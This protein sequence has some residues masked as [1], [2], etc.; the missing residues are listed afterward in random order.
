MTTYNL[1]HKY[2]SLP[3][4]IIGTKGIKITEANDNGHPL[5]E[6]HI[7]FSKIESISEIENISDHRLGGNYVTFTIICRTINR[8]MS[9]KKF[10][11]KMSDNTKLRELH[12]CI[13]SV[14]QR[15]NKIKDNLIGL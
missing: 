14:I 13:E 10:E 8:P 4:I 3:S 5:P 1:W 15:N 2:S 7:L 11:I 6:E 12:N 9:I